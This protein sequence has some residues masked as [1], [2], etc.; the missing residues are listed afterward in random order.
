MAA[1][2]LITQDYQYEYNSLLIGWNTD[3]DVE[4]LAGLFGFPSVRS[5]TEDA[6][7]MHGGTPGRHY[8]PSRVFTVSLNIHGITDD[9]SFATLKYE[10]TKAF[11]PRSLPRILPETSLGTAFVSGEIPFVYQ[12]PGVGERRRFVNCRPI[13]MDFPANRR[14]AL[15]YPHVDLRLE[16]SDPRHYSYTTNIATA[17]LPTPGGGLDFPLTFPLNFGV[18]SSNAATLENAGNADAHWVAEITGPVSNPR[19]EVTSNMDDTDIHFIQFSGL[20]L[21][22]GETLVLSSRYRSV[23]LGG[24]SRRSFVVPGSLWFTI[25]PYPNSLSLRYSSDDPSPT[26]STATVTWN[27]AYWG[28]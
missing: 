22:S 7:G 2:D 16:A 27:N 11:G 28:H 20:S 15:Q 13:G 1:G 24:Q 3:Y 23:L 12:H 18:G 25:P 21:I 9:E 6:F 4:E 19:L 14:Y 5:S 8:L 26:G 10:I 17:N